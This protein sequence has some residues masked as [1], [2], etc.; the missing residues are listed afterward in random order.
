[1][2]KRAVCVFIF[3]GLLWLSAAC[4]PAATPVTAPAVISDALKAQLS[5][6]T[7][8]DILTNGEFLVK[9][10]MLCQSPPTVIQGKV[11]CSQ[12][13][14]TNLP[15]VAEESSSPVVLL[16]V[17]DFGSLPLWRVRTKPSFEQDPGKPIL[18]ALPTAVPKTGDNCLM[19]PGGQGY[20]VSRRS[21]GTESELTH[22]LLIFQ[23]LEQELEKLGW[24]RVDQM[25]S[26]SCW[27]RKMALYQLG[28]DQNL[29]LVG[30]DTQNYDTQTVSN[31]IEAAIDELTNYTIYVG[32]TQLPPSNRFVINMSFAI[33]PCNTFDFYSMD[34]DAVF[35]QQD[36]FKSSLSAYND[37]G[38]AGIVNNMDVVL[39][40]LGPIETPAPTA[41]GQIQLSEQ[42]LKALDQL[43]TISDLVGS[44]SF[45]LQVYKPPKN[46]A[47]IE[48]YITDALASIPETDSLVSLLKCYA[49]NP[50][51]KI[52]SIASAGNFNM[53]PYPFMPALL[54]SVISVS[55]D[56]SRIQ[57]CTQ[58]EA[59]YAASNGGELV[60][61]GIF[62]LDGKCNLGTSFAAPRLSLQAT[63]M[64]LAGAD[65]PDNGVVP[66]LGYATEYG[67][68]SNL[69][70]DDALV[71][72]CP[73]VQDYIT[74]PIAPA[75]EE[76]AIA[77]AGPSFEAPY[78]SSPSLDG[79]VD[80][81]FSPI[82]KVGNISYG[83]ADWGGESD[84]WADVQF[85]WDEGYLYLAAV[86]R[87]D[88]YVQAN[89][90]TNIYRGDGL[91]VLL[92]LDLRGDIDDQKLSAD[93]YAVILS[94]GLQE[95]GNNPEAVLW[96]NDA[97]AMPAE[98]VYMAARRTEVGYIM[99]AA[100]P[101]KLF[102]VS[103]NPE[104]PYGIAFN[105]RD[106][107]TGGEN[108]QSLVTLIPGL[109][110]EN[111]TTWGSLYIHK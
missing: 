56:Y 27:K 22:G 9:A 111:P 58:E 29:L 71:D 97:F 99:E 67:A 33:V 38:L 80:D 6:S 105:I 10:A 15:V 28:A 26:D 36:L 82:N 74:T 62:K 106:N 98:K 93:D 21:S 50:S 52:I 40:R 89:T 63:L 65:C 17:D 107:D 108:I 110:W 68:F 70:L 87:D 94:P 91:E 3:G 2:I 13:P 20:Y 92:D 101:W 109:V 104:Q 42:T 47:E 77:R 69:S 83:E 7:Y 96:V 81:W 100:I 78:W 23:E 14:S 35:K 39:Q 16:V 25:D 37:P 76:A 45:F 88:A 31:N 103:A 75:T 60:M 11:D 44:Y 79:V 46:Q 53:Y 4:A 19:E 18:D 5:Q 30:I 41:E 32:N 48:Q 61:D 57:E 102:G 24:K 54:D 34:L 51:R 73:D 86:V 55:A 95:P 1:M 59:Q 66:P 90:G 85:A 84:A 72:Y 43:Q 64:L 8:A 12:L 49:Y